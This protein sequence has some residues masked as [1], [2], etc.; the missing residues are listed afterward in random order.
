MDDLH[1]PPGPGAPRGLRLPASELLEQFSHASG[2]GGQGVNTSD[3][4]VQLSWDVA[5]TTALDDAQ[6]ARVLERLGP[7]LAGT[8]LTVTASAQRS[9]RR[10]RVAAR[11]R[12]AE[13]LREA[14]M[15]P[16]PRR[17]TR[18]TRGSQRRRLEAKK[19]R[20]AVKQTR[21]RPG[22]E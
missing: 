19:L 1:V 22:A 12:L 8:V 9:Q 20:G 17:A 3:S 6:R 2:P 14:V 4:R 7:R 5:A 15:P 16:V 21:R 18:P 13:L 10:N 11:E